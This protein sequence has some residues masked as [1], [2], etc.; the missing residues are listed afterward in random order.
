MQIEEKNIEA[1]AGY[2]AAGCKNCADR[3]VGVET[4]HFVIN[5]QGEPIT[6]GD[7]ERIMQKLVRKGDTVVVEDEYFLGY[8]ND[9]FSITLEPA[10]QLEISVMPQKDLQ[11]MERILKKFYVDYGDALQKAGFKMVNVGYHP[12]RKAEEL[13]LIPKKRYEYMN[14]YFAHSGSRGYQMMRATASTQVSVDYLNE[15]DFIKKYRLACALVPVFSLITENCPVY[16]GRKNDR[17]LTRSFVWQD[18]DV[19][20]CLI[21]DCTFK[22]DFGFRTYAEELYRKP[23]ILVKEGSLTYSTENQTIAQWYH[24]KELDKAEIEHLLSMFFP[25]V[26]LKQYLEIRPADSLPVELVLGYVALVRGIFYRKEI[27]DE[28]AEYFIVKDKQEIE[29]A[30]NNLMEHGYAGEVYGKPVTEVVDLLFA[31]VMEYA[32]DVE[33]KMLEP[34]AVMAKRRMTPA[35][36]LWKDCV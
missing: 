23:P 6:Y 7:L 5:E 4:E 32:D 25:D 28:L 30:K 19:E 34:L 16:E 21:P 29:A 13:S 8:Y 27:L 35:E 14:A 33:K 1:I 2:F 15:A 26:R 9:D 17:F 12:T 22:E 10:A 18:V 3:H 11:G 20:R 24:N 36:F 31:R